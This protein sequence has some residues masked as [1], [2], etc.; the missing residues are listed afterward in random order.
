MFPDLPF[1][2]GNLKEDNL[3]SI[4]LSEKSKIFTH[5]VPKL[6]QTCMECRYLELCNGGCIG[7]AYHKYK[8]FG[9][10]DPRCPKINKQ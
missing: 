5:Y 6:E 3:N 8:E 10:G 9:Y 4:L 7:T 1:P 2:V